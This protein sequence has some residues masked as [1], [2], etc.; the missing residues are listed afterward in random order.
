MCVSPSKT[1]THSATGTPVP[2]QVI[3]SPRTCDALKGIRDQTNT[4]GSLSTC[5]VNNQCDT[6]KC[7]VLDEYTVSFQPNPCLDPPGIHVIVNEGNEEIYNEII[8]ETTKI[9]VG[10]FFS[11]TVNLKLEDDGFVMKVRQSCLTLYVWDRIILY[12]N[13]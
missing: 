5:S 10:D 1:N 6:L 11:L 8:T 7:V 3:V 12:F 4:G 13:K 9:P 2:S